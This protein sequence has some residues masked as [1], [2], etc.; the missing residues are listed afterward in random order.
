MTAGELQAMADGTDRK[1]RRR[2]V[3]RGQRRGPLY[4][5][6]LLLAVLWSGSALFLSGGLSGEQVAD[7]TAALPVVEEPQQTLPAPEVEAGFDAEALRGRLEEIAGEHGGVYGVAVLE[8]V[9]G[10]GVSLRG[11]EG[12]VTASI[13]KL[14]PFLALYRAAARGELDLEEEIQILPTD[15]QSYGSGEL[16]SFPVGYSMSLR[17]CAFWLVNRSDNTAWMM[18]NR[19]LGDE[20]IRAELE[21]MGA[22]NALYSN[23]TDYVATPE[24][25]LLML[26]KISD[27]SYTSA[28]LSTEM[29]AAMTDTVSEDRIPEK[30]PA[31]VRVAHKFGSYGDNFGDAGIVFYEDGQGVEKRY[32][33]VVLSRGTGEYDARDAIQSMSLA[34]YEALVEDTTGEDT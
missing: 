4:G 16:H 7:A 15:V 30:L 23:L 18:L 13:G 12:F 5:L 3:R 28:E 21:E 34:V 33:L 20:K 29:L 22:E 9:S 32:Y 19:R 11:D 14:P 1:D 27:P 10:T 25:V 2:D 8:P 17:E 6:S 24:D 31:A 26:Q